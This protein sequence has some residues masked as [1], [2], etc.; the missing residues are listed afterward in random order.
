[1]STSFQIPAALTMQTQDLPWAHG[2]LAPGLSIQL[3]I[4]DVEAGMF[5]VKTRFQPGTVIPTHLH[6]GA[7]HGFTESGSW[8]YREYGAESLNV[9]G[10]Y[11]YEPPGSTH[12]LEVAS[13]ITEVTDAIFI[14]HG[15][16]VNLDE[17]GN[18]LNTV[19]AGAARDLYFGLLEEQGEPRPKIIV[20]GN[21]TYSN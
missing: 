13:D 18:L 5:V 15:A 2:A 14:I 10:S 4:A 9:A 11:I 8:H 21:C 16:L 3:F 20:G 19:D 12:T 1:M 7:V 6:T 17:S